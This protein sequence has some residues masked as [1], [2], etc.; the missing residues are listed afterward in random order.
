MPLESPR[1]AAAQRPDPT[2]RQQIRPL[3]GGVARFPAS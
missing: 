3:R 1:H 2:P